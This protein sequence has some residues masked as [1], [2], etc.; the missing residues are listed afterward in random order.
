MRFLNRF[1]LFILL[2]L[3][4]PSLQIQAYGDTF[5]KNHPEDRMDGNVS[6]EKTE[7]QKEVVKGNWK[8]KWDKKSGKLKKIRGG[9]GMTTEN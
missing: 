5:V 2:S 7:R 3:F 8:L 6:S 4:L 1:F 9:I